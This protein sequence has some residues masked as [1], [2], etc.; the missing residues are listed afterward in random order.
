MIGSLA[1]LLAA[2]EAAT[3]WLRASRVEAA[4]VGGVAASIHGQP[5][6]TKDVDFVVLAD[7]EDCETLLARAGSFG[8]SPRIEDVVEFARTTRV[9]LLRHETSGVELDVS[10]G[11]LPFERELVT[12]G[13]SVAVSGV[14]FRVARPEDIII[15][16]ALALRP[17]DI[18][19]IEAIAHAN[20]GL[21]LGR[22]RATV[23]EFSEIL[24]E[25]DL[26]GELD[27]ILGTARGRR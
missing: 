8:I 13:R 18:A 7:V 27:R 23:A 15:M 24:E 26:L 11:S 12:H 2:I 3:S 22:I 6:V 19:D 5:R 1:P 14:C 20:P 25:A 21:D 9:L 17:R 10:L 16:K 4:V